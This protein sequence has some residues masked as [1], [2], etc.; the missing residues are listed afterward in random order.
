MK[1]LRQLAVA[2]SG[3]AIAILLT[4][5]AIVPAVQ[6]ERGRGD[7][8]SQTIPLPEL[9]RHLQPDIVTEVIPD[10][11]LPPPLDDGVL[12]RMIE[13]RPPL[14]RHLPEQQVEV[15]LMEDGRMFVF[16]PNRGRQ[17]MGQVEPAVLEQFKRLLRNPEFLNYNATSWS[18]LNQ[19]E[20]GYT[21]MLSSASVTI[22]LK[23]QFSLSEA[24]L[25]DSVVA[26]MNTFGYMLAYLA[27]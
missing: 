4:F 8:I 22:E 6:A 3:M 14:Q 19:E 23:G 25:P 5:A 11:E 24:L 20:T 12:F 15:H 1:H 2:A 9:D 7:R 27:A 13:R 21:V 17:P 26:V 10:E 18:N 16:Q